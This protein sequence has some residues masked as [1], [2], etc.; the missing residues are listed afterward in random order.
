MQ[1]IIT[2][3][4][5]WEWKYI[6]MFT[7]QL[8]DKKCFS[9]SHQ[10]LLEKLFHHQRIFP[11]GIEWITILYRQQ[12]E[13]WL[14]QDNRQTSDLKQ[15]NG[16]KLADNNINDV[17]PNKGNGGLRVREFKVRESIM[18]TLLEDYFVVFICLNFI[19]IQS[20]LTENFLV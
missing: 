3:T 1:V 10:S 8:T 18:R 16:Y 6:H 9:P 20:G 15:E 12:V 17:K 19:V 14:F 2:W 5:I 11:C 4:C 13:Q 7:I